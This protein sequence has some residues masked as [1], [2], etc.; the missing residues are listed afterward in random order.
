M[1]DGDA[2]DSKY[3]HV[4]LPTLRGVEDSGIIKL[5]QHNNEKYVKN[6]LIPEMKCLRSWHWLSLTREFN[7]IQNFVY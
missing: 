1:G 2:C 7:C 3:M 6:V 5:V 4:Q